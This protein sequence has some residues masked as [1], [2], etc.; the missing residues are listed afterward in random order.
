VSRKDLENAKKDAHRT[1]RLGEEW[2][3]SYL[4]TK[5]R[6]NLILN[7][8]WIAN[9]N[10]ISPYDFSIVALDESVILIDVKTT[11]GDFNNRIHISFN[12]LLQMREAQRYDL[13]RVFSIEDDFAQLRIAK[14]IKSFAINI[15]EV[16]QNLP[17][18][19]KSDGISVS[20]SMLNFGEIENI[21]YQE[22]EE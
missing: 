3:L 14:D 5:K 10:A 22:E 8:N 2:V 16:L 17:S 4:E 21:I 18:G 13:Y 1:G 15:I 7:F 11:K 6:N 12:E 20:P 9:E 19:V